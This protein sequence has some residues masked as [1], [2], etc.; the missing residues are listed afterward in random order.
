MILLR[1][2][3]MFWEFDFQLRSDMRSTENEQSWFLLVSF[4]WNKMLD[5]LEIAQDE[6]VEAI[7]S[8]PTSL[9]SL[10]TLKAVELEAIAVVTSPLGHGLAFPKKENPLDF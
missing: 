5:S 10:I 4:F 9:L 3:F 8:V 6:D 7:W 2:S 1:V